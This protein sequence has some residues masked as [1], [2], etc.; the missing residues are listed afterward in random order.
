MHQCFN[1]QYITLCAKSK[2][3]EAFFF[4]LSVWNKLKAWPVSKRP[5][6]KGEKVRLRL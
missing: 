2:C 4:S 1:N 3:S 6:H 5:I